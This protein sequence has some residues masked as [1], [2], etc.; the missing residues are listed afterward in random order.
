MTWLASSRLHIALTRS[1][2][3]RSEVVSSRT[4]M[5][6][7][8]RTSVSSPKP[9]DARPC[10]TVTPCGSLTTGFGT[11]TIRA[12]TARD[13]GERSPFVPR[14]LREERLAHEAQVRR[15]VALAGLGDDLGRQG[16]RIGLLV[17]SR[18]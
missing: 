11:T 6:L 8:T 18:A 1:R 7:P 2:A 17:P 13:L 3:S 12:I 14:L 9:S 16:R 4:S 15:Q 10:R 5:Y